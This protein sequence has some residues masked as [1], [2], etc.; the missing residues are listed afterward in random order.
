MA[1]IV[2]KRLPKPLK[3]PTDGSQIKNSVLGKLLKWMGNSKPKGSKSD[4]TDLS[5]KVLMDERIIIN[6]QTTPDASTEKGTKKKRAYVVPTPRKPAPQSS[7]KPTSRV[8]FA[9]TKSAGVHETKPPNKELSTHRSNTPHPMTTTSA[10]IDRMRENCDHYRMMY[11]IVLMEQQQDHL[12]NVINSIRNLGNKRHYRNMVKIKEA[13]SKLYGTLLSLRD[14]DAGAYVRIGSSVKDLNDFFKMV[15]NV[16]SAV[17]D[18]PV[19]GSSQD[20]KATTKPDI[21]EVMQAM[22]NPRSVKLAPLS[23]GPTK[24]YMKEKNNLDGIFFQNGPEVSS[25]YVETVKTEWPTLNTNDSGMQRK[26]LELRNLMTEIDD[27][28]VE[29]GLS[30]GDVDKK[31]SYEELMAGITTAPEKSDRVKHC[32]LKEKETKKETKSKK[33]EDDMF[34]DELDQLLDAADLQAAE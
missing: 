20:Q 10:N 15:E 27:L 11:L 13:L 1:R 7:H 33:E 9:S 23:N 32:F 16:C 18:I 34:I 4:K 8:A 6:G 14:D 28:M 2:E 24:L 19:E 21:N 29:V 22:R 3:P 31:I 26:D 17:E 30:G 25:K 12:R 5:T